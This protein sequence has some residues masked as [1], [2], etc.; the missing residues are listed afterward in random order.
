V[1]RA[2]QL[3]LVVGADHIWL[4]WAM[5][6]EK[7]TLL[8][9]ARFFQ[10]SRIATLRRVHSPLHDIGLLMRPFPILALTQQIAR[11]SALSI[12][13][14]PRAVAALERAHR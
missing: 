4:H 6:T 3:L 9:E 14:K 10:V 8:A 7:W 1:V 2:D 11:R 12:K 13:N 5:S